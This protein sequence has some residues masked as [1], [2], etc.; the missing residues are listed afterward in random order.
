MRPIRIILPMLLMMSTAMMAQNTY[1]YWI[2]GGYASHK[3]VSGT[4][5]SITM[6]IS[7]LTP[8]LH[9]F[10]YRVVSGET[11]NNLYRSLFFIPQQSA[12]TAVPEQCEYEYWIDGDYA[13]HQTANGNASITLSTESLTPG[14]HA[15]Y[16]REVN[17]N[18]S[19]HHLSN[20]LF[21][22]PRRNADTVTPEQLEYEYWID[23]D[24]TNHKTVS[25]NA[26]VTVSIDGLTP[27]LHAF[28]YRVVNENGTWNNLSHALFFIP[29]QKV[30]QNPEIAA[31]EYWIDDNWENRQTAL[32]AKNLSQ[33][34]AS[35]KGLSE[36]EH[37]FVIRVK[38]TAGTWS[39]LYYIPFEIVYKPGDANGDDVVDVADVVSIVNYILGDIA[40][41]FKIRAANVDGEVNED[42]TPNISVSDVVGVVN[43][44]L[45]QPATENDKQE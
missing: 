24:Y 41:N 29:Q 13:N 5:T 39:G 33:L 1:E 9:A 15:F 40:E 30:E 6:P 38:N 4:N 32:D 23:G 2:D 10:Y 31:Y 18:G 21:F 22:I 37:Q 27:G 45:E 17:P 42:G 12:E 7:D 16:Y 11:W 19:W 43:I 35:I 34:T 8:G 36:G 26:G 44:I 20:T 3:T 14:L 25:G 28:Y